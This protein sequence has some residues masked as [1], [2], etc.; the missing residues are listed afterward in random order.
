[1]VNYKNKK[2]K[3]L[4]LPKSE[5]VQKNYVLM[6]PVFSKSRSPIHSCIYKYIFLIFYNIQLFITYLQPI[7]ICWFS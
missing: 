2:T 1:M 4:T 3:L 7:L 5:N 6:Y